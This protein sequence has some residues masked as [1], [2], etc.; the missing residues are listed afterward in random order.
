MMLLWLC[1]AFLLS[2][3]LARVIEHDMRKPLILNCSSSGTPE[4]ITWQRKRDNVGTWSKKYGAVVQPY[5]KDQ[6][7]IEGSSDNRWSTL[8]ITDPGVNKEGAWDCLVNTLAQGKV[9]T[10]FYYQ[11]YY[12]SQISFL[13][14]N[15]ENGHWYNCS[16][17]GYPKMTLATEPL[18]K[19]TG[20]KPSPNP[21]MSFIKE[22]QDNKGVWHLSSGIFIPFSWYK[23]LTV[24]CLVQHRGVNYTIDMTDYSHPPTE[25]NLD[26]GKRAGALTSSTAL[27][28]LVG[29]LFAL[30]ILLSGFLWWAY[31][32]RW[33][34]PYP[35]LI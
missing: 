2:D 26:L 3:S 6:V 23:D 24:W 32:K 1:C 11:P 21:F 28:V 7:K 27:W 12:P 20:L 33:L 9:P 4:I 29:V 19:S 17:L 8:T 35:I 31:H 34:K 5:Y 14:S 18:Y 13:T 22:Y 25:T 10:T 30:L 15:F 16:V